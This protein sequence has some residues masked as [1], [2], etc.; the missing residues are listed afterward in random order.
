MDSFLALAESNTQTYDICVVIEG[1][2]PLNVTFQVQVNDIQ[3][4]AGKLLQVFLQ[5]YTTL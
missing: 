3:L 2:I 1:F 5:L 4:S